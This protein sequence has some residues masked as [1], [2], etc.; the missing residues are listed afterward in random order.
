M[1]AMGER[2]VRTL[3][4]AAIAAASFAGL[5]TVAALW[6]NPFFIRMVPAGAMEILL[7]AALSALLGT[8]VA[9]RRRDCP[10]GTIGSGGVLGFLGIAC[11]V[12]NQLLMLLFGAELL[13]TYYEPVRVYVAATGVLIAGGAVW[14]ELVRRKRELSA[15]RQAGTT[16]A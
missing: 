10:V 1:N 4:G 15:P 13:L 3:K 5:G 8:F 2:S 6:D 12:C 7:L 9:V 14:I 11:P 16:A